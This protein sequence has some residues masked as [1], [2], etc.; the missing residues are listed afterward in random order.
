[1]MGNVASKRVSLFLV[2]CF[3]FQMTFM[4]AFDNNRSSS[5]INDEDPDFLLFDAASFGVA[6]GFSFQ[7]IFVFFAV[8]GCYGFMACFLLVFFP[9]SI[10]NIGLIIIIVVQLVVFNR[11]VLLG[12]ARTHPLHKFLLELNESVKFIIHSI[13]DT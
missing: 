8:W 12:M 7:V 2:K 1:M 3:G 11:M 6:I 5:G 13:D 9:C 10:A 4:Y